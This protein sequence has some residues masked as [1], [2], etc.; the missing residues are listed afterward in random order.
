[1]KP[2]PYGSY[3]RVSSR[4]QVKQA[5]IQT[6]DA[7]LRAS[8]LKEG[9]DP[10]TEVYWFRDEGISGDLPIWERDG[11]SEMRE[12]VERGL[13]T[14]EIRAYHLDR[15]NRDDVLSYFELELLCDE[16][17]LTL[18]TIIDNVDTSTE[19]GQLLGGL[20][21]LLARK[22]K[23]EQLERLYAGRLRQIRAGYWPLHA[24]YGHTRSPEGKLIRDEQAIAVIEEAVRL[25]RDERWSATAIVEEL[26]AR[27]IPGPRGGRW[28]LSRLISI[29]R[30]TSLIGKA[31]YN[32]SRAIRKRGRVLGREMRP[33]EEYI[34]VS[35][36]RILD[37]ATFYDVQAI[38][39]TNEALYHKSGAIASQ[40]MLQ[41]VVCRQCNQRFY[42]HRKR[43]RIPGQYLFYYTHRWAK[44]NAAC[45]N[46]GLI[47]AERLDTVVW[48][49]VLAAM[50]NTSLWQN[51]VEQQLYDDSRLARRYAQAQER[52]D[53]A[54]RSLSRLEEAHFIRQTL[55]AE[56][57]DA[58]APQLTET[59]TR[60][61]QEVARLETQLATHQAQRQRM[62]ETA[63][64]M[65]EILRRAE[66]ATPE[67]KQTIC[68]KLI[69][70]VVVLREGPR[71]AF[72]AEIVWL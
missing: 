50:R 53:E 47:P 72:Q 33:E 17:D 32:R 12:Y 58:L 64:Y 44:P 21:A 71:D 31:M 14:K 46:A 27:G 51:E 19:S 37:D 42:A 43:S 48:E 24:P 41:R 3:E 25:L 57:Y 13:V 36:P 26:E 45:P 70:E 40:M 55:T 30:N 29:L 65:T 67:L 56:R 66:N 49:R 69:R 6:Q 52:L 15:V 35:C 38:L 23:R 20:G 39:D 54:Q 5:T 22:A 34:I 9:I 59:L 1:M 68:T 8:Y 7:E 60:A 10:D 11:A 62:A 18:R 4:T 28:H 63:A 2:R 16:Y 61:R